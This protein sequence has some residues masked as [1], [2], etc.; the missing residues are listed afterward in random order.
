MANEEGSEIRVLIVDDTVTYRVIL[1]S[2][3][4]KFDDVEVVGQAQNGLIAIR[5]TKE[6]QPDLI[7]LDI[8]MPE[9]DGFETLKHI[10][11]FDDYAEVV[12]VSGQ[13]PDSVNRTLDTLREG[14]LD[15]IPKPMEKDREHSVQFLVDALKPIMT[16]TRIRMNTKQARGHTAPTPKR[17]TTMPP[18]AKK[19]ATP[20]VP[21]KPAVKP[22]PEKKK[23][24]TDTATVPR[25]LRTAPRAVDLV[26]IG[27]S[28]G[29]P[30]ALQVMAPSLSK[31][32]GCPILL[33]QH[34]PPMFTKQLAERLDTLTELNVAEATHGEAV[35]AGKVYIAPGGIHMVL[36]KKGEHLVTELVDSPP[37]NSCKPAVDVLFESVAL[38]GKM[39][40]LTVIMTGMG[41]DG[42]DGVKILRDAGAYSLIQSEETCT[43]WGMPAAVKESGEF[44]EEVQLEDLGSRISDMAVRF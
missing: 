39:K 42:A 41:H 36:S 2:V 37:V 23:Q 11:Q 33:V 18:S 31:D 38:L 10:R 5:K 29:G 27:I 16:A 25:I 28:T 22:Q 24:V 6:L 3:L 44:D 9:M 4:E 35:K 40:I 15:F 43:I 20:D 14:A 21:T 1:K 13:A 17:A 26:L 7:L 32:I 12:I 30:N 34:M 19:A 8:E